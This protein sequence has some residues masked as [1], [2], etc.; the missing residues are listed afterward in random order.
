MQSNFIRIVRRFICTLI[1]GAL[2]SGCGGGGTGG[3]TQ[4]SPS[5]NAAASSSTVPSSNVPFVNPSPTPTLTSSGTGVLHATLRNAEGQPLTNGNVS[6]V[7]SN[8][9]DQV[10][11]DSST[12]VLTAATDANGNVTLNGLVSGVPYNLT[13]NAPGFQTLQV[14]LTVPSATQQLQISIT[15]PTGSGTSTFTAP[16]PVTLNP[17]VANGNQVTLTWSQS[18]ASTFIA[19]VLYSSTSSSVT[20]ASGGVLTTLTSIGDTSYVD[21]T[22]SSLGSA[23]FYVVYEEV[24]DPVTGITIMIGSNVVSTASPTVSSFSPTGDDIGVNIPIQI[25]FSGL[26]DQDAIANNLMVTSTIANSDQLTSGIIPD[27]I[28]GTATW[29]GNTLTFTPTPSWDYVRTYT[30]QLPDENL[31]YTFSTKTGYK[32]DTAFAS[33]DLGMLSYLGLSFVVDRSNNVIV[34]VAQQQPNP[35]VPISSIVFNRY[36]STGTL[37]DTFSDNIDSYFGFFAVDK[38][39]GLWEAAITSLTPPVTTLHRYDNN[40][41]LLFS[42]PFDASALRAPGSIEEYLAV[43]LDRNVAYSSGGPNN[44]SMLFTVDLTT[45]VTTALRTFDP[46]QVGALIWG[47]ALDSNGDL[48]VPYAPSYGP[49][50]IMKLDP[51]ANTL[52]TVAPT[53]PVCTVG[54]DDS[55]YFAQRYLP[56]GSSGY[57]NSWRFWKISPTGHVISNFQVTAPRNDLGRMG[58]DSN[59]QL[60]VQFDDVIQR[61]IVDP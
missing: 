7:R 50:A 59:G 34:T 45:G 39:N 58:A 2:I 20:S 42:L 29:S 3:A 26:V 48:Y 28:Q 49:S 1:V 23:V 47:G 6:A 52:A 14:T 56:I 31:T 21:T 5:N 27:D 22:A 13:I 40:G 24:Q 60:Y 41:N 57:L 54:N 61:Y 9:M 53:Y 17:P 8:Q 51:S 38:L 44:Y 30:V 12:V 25:T 11:D 15:V 16:S 33:T 37:T 32:V 43:D 18:Q 36:D 10:R 35:S 4:S 19:Y 46:L 55:L